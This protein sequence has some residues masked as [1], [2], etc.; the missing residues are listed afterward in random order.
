M[1]N[2]GFSEKKWKFVSI[3]L[4][5]ILAVG[6]SF[7]QVFAAASANLNDIFNKLTTVDQKVTNIGSNLDDG[8]YGQIV[9]ATRHVKA[10]VASDTN[11]G[12]AVVTLISEEQEGVI[13]STD[14]TLLGSD[15]GVSTSN[16][17]FLE[18]GGEEVA[19]NLCNRGTFDLEPGDSIIYECTIPGSHANTRCDAEVTLWMTLHNI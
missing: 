11:K 19:F 12:R 4:M 10:F 15:T 9:T 5:A 16:R 8:K 3:S 2:N 6:F 14:C 18:R 7:P 17:V 1:E 13:Q